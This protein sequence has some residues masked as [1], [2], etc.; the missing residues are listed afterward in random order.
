MLDTKS[1]NL[2]G[3]LNDEESV[4]EEFENWSSS[5]SYICDVISEISDSNIPIYNADLWANAKYIQEHIEQ[6]IEE[7]L[8]EGVTDLMKVFQVGFYVYY[9]ASLYQNLGALVYNIIVNNVNEYLNTLGES[10]LDNLD[11]AEIEEAIEEE[12]ENID[13]NDMFENIESIANEIIERIKDGEF[14]ILDDEDEDEEEE[15]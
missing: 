5:S 12:S 1:Y 2:I 13:N 14:N 15:E 4:L 11:L 10:K 3:N 7:G 8:V 9:N 6:G